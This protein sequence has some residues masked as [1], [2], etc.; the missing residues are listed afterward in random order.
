VTPQAVAAAEEV[1]RPVTLLGVVE[2]PVAERDTVP[3]EAGEVTSLPYRP[4]LDGLRALAVYLVVLF[5]AGSGIFAGGYIG[6]DVFFVLSGFLVTQLLLRDLADRGTIRLRRFYARRFRR[7]LPAAFVALITTAIVFTAIASPSEVLDAAGSFKAAFLYVTNWYF[8]HHAS[9]YFGADL[10]ANPVLQFWSLAVEEQFYL[11]WPLTMGA[12]FVIARRLGRG[13]L[14]VLRAVVVIG[15]LASVGWALALRHTD[16]NRAYYGTDARA[17]ELLTGALL[18]LAPA[19][20]AWAARHRRETRVGAGI[21]LVALVLVGSSWLHFGAIERG[22]AATVITAA[23][24]VTVENAGGGLVQ[25]SLSGKTVV[26]LGKISYGT[27][28]WHWLVILV[29]VRTFRTGT[30]ATL[31]IA[32]FLATAL[33]ALSYELLERPVRISKLLD[34]RA[35][36]VV[37]AGLTISVA[38]AVVLIP[39]IVDPARAATPLAR[40]SAVSGFTPVPAGLD[41]RDA[42][43]GGGPFVNCLGRPASDC[44]IV[45]GTGRRVLLMGDSNAWMMIPAFTEIARA[46]NLTLSVSVRGGCPWQRDLYVA[47]IT[48]DGR[49]LRTADCR[50]QKDDAYA[51]VIPALNP[52][53]IVVMQVAHEHPGLTPFLGPDGKVVKSGTSASNRWVEETTRRS[54]PELLAH[55]RELLIIEPIPVAPFDPVACIS[56]AKVLEECRFVARTQPDAIERFYRRLAARNRDVHSADFDRLVCPYLPICDPVVNHQLVMRDADHLT[57]RFVQSLAPA[58]GRYLEDVGLIPR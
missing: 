17:F 42:K 7:L 45:R 8:I 52:D 3:F 20:F 5:H 39:R 41:W 48:V 46:H 14:R 32:V 19:L 2:T 30:A 47:P 31:A 12:V 9:G 24:L 18:A 40:S 25:R 10:T 29:A 22:V 54:V 56:K 34:G 26:Y 23:I 16:P 57:L 4:H 35:A 11:L 15:A 33:A 37:A 44:T 1:W 49:T 58:I 6:V 27:Y 36:F 28:L 53:V 50:A 55:G 43:K 51:R 38:S 21:G 13:E